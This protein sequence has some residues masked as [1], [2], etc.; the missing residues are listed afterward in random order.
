M[1]T[2]IAINSIAFAL[3]VA[4]L[5]FEVS[6]DNTSIITVPD[7]MY[8]AEDGS[9]RLL[10]ARRQDINF[11]LVDESPKPTVAIDDS[12]NYDQQVA[13]DAVITEMETNPLPQRRDVDLHRRDVIIETSNGY[14][15]NVKI[16]DASISA[17]KN[18]QGSDTFLGS[19]LFTSGPFDTTLCAAACTAQSEYNIRHPPTNGV[20]KTCQFYNTYA[21]YRDGVYQ[22]Q[23]CSMYTQAWDASYAKNDGQWRGGVHYTMGMSYIASNATQSGDV[24]CPSDVPYL[25]Q[26]GA[27]FC[28]AFID[29][30]PPTSTVSTLT[31]TPAVSILVSTQSSFITNTAYTTQLTTDVQTA[32]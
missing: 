28:T 18:C 21:M 13:I 1:R 19:K 31:V 5:P 23:Y 32:T 12:S 17:P 9:I 25:S 22:G 26:N 3:S 8:L 16:K 4:A 7:G 15:S 24:S 29:Y 10:L 6:S 30:V 27:A 20:A 14:T 11:D 2:S